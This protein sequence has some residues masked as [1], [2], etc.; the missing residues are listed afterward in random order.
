[1]VEIFEKFKGDHILMYLKFKWYQQI[2]IEAWWNAKGEPCNGV[3]SHPGRSS[4]KF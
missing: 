2:V 3:A 1:M 4:N